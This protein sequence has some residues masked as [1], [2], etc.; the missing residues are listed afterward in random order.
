M[1]LPFCCSYKTVAE[2][3]Q[4]WRNVV[5]ETGVA[6]VAVVAAVLAVVAIAAVAAIVAVFV[7]DVT[8]ISDA[9]SH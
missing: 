7:A 6:S 4:H 3:Q 1:L 8:A 5:A 9:Y 2:K